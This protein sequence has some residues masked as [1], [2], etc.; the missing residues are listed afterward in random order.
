VLAG[1]EAAAPESQE[2]LAR[3]ARARHIGLQVIPRIE[4][5]LRDLLELE[6]FFDRHPVNAVFGE[7]VEG[8]AG[9]ATDLFPAETFQ[10]GDE[11]G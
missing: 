9:A 3:F 6:R 1:V 10:P 2:G 4:V 8:S 5:E 11:A 7:M